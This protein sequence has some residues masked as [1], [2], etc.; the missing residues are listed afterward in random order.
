[1]NER[2]TND[3]QIANMWFAALKHVIRRPAEIDFRYRLNDHEQES[4]QYVET[5]RMTEVDWRAGAFFKDS[6]K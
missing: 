1:M 5:R 3:E 2:V 6:L 4:E